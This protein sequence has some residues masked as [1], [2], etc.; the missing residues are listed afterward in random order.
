MDTSPGGEGLKSKLFWNGSQ[1]N[2][3]FRTILDN[4]VKPCLKTKMLLKKLRNAETRT[5]SELYG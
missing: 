3:M 1:E 5:R 2:H 4:L